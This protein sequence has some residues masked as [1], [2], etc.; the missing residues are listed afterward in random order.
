[1]KTN[2]TKSTIYLSAIFAIVVA[3]PTGAQTT[4][5]V[6]ANANV[7]GPRDGTSWDRAYEFLQDALDPTV[8]QPGDTIRIA[9]GTYHPDDT[10]ANPATG[11]RNASFVLLAHV[12]IEGGYAGFGAPE[13][14]DHVVNDGSDHGDVCRFVG[15]G[16]LATGS[17]GQSLGE[18]RRS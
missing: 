14:R 10:A 3:A 18:P 13:R 17:R 1:M 8:A 7:P 15:A 12:I 4:W 6:D 16:R 5:F 9:D 11:N 2:P